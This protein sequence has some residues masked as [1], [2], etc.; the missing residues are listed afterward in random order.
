MLDVARPDDAVGR[1]FWLLVAG[2]WLQ[3]FLSIQVFS[4]SVLHSCIPAFMHYSIPAF[5]HLI[6]TA[7]QLRWSA[8]HCMSGYPNFELISISSFI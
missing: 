2:Y 8:K 6:F 5:P 1:G 3:V 4:F 7:K